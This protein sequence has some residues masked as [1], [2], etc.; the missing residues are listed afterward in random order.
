MKQ[1]RKLPA[2]GL[3]AEAADV[4]TIVVAM[5]VVAHVRLVNRVG[6]TQRSKACARDSGS[7]PQ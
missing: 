5:T 3:V 6:K 7:C 1:G 2:A 4:A